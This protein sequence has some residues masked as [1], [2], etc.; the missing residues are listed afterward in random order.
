[1]GSPPR[2]DPLVKEFEGCRWDADR[3]NRIARYLR[4]P[5]ELNDVVFSTRLNRF[6]FCANSLDELR[7]AISTSSVPAEPD[8]V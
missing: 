4:E 5:P 3:L 1:M 6:E 2:P 8:Q 7:D